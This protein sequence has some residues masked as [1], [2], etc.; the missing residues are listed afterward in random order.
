MQIFL[1]LI[2]L[3]LVGLTILSAVMLVA[4]NTSRRESVVQNT[5]LTQLQQQVE[6]IRSQQDTL[7]QSLEKN[8]RSGQENISNF[9]TSSQRTFGDLKEQIG[10]LKSDSEHLLK[11]GADIR[12]L[13]NILQTPKLRGQMGDFSLASLLKQILPADSFV[14][15]HTFSSG[16][17][18]DALIRLPDFAVSVDAKFPLPAF[19]QMMA[20]PDETE[21]NRL[22]RQFQSDVIK[23]IDKI[24][25]SYILPG[26]G[27]LDFAL[28]Y[29]PAENVYYE[30]IIKYDTD[31]ADLL[32]HAMN[33]KVIPVSPNLLYAYLMTIVMG[34]HGLQIEKEA[35]AIRVNLQKLT[36]GLEGFSG[37]WDILGRHLRNASSQYDEGHN[38]LTQFKL[39]LENIQHHSIDSER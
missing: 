20:A 35:A 26:E 18:V 17:I 19:E 5:T 36:A 21:K 1:I 16:K 27:T 2:S 4:L 34:L 13:Q 15:Q 32:E 14:L 9:L 23:H 11:I 22:R 25:Q 28:M 3:L 30:T 33:K 6:T 7:N 39:Q 8:L 31:R 24:A 29:I 38:K 12:T 10:K 37:N